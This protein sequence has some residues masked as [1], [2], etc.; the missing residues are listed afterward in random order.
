MVYLRVSTSRD[1]STDAQ[2]HAIESVG[3]KADRVFVDEGITGRRIDRPGLQ[4]ML[5][6]VR[7]GDTVV[8]YSL[9]RISRSTKDL[10]T[11]LDGLDSM[12]VHLVSVSE[13]INTST[14]SGRLLITVLSAISQFEVDTLRDRTLSGLEA[15]RAQGRVGG[16]PRALDGEQLVVARGLRASGWSYGRIAGHLSVGKSTVH[17]ALT[18]EER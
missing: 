13:S 4:A 17:R 5:S 2:R 9:S 15:A 1:Q 3:W 6:W 16:R 14:P 18:E 7:D 10:L 8:V 12:G 11:L